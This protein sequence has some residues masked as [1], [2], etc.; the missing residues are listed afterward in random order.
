MND[1]EGGGETFAACS[2][3][4]LVEKVRR[5]REENWWR[6]LGSKG[7]GAGVGSGVDTR[8]RIEIVRAVVAAEWYRRRG[9]EWLQPRET[10]SRLEGGGIRIIVGEKDLAGYW[11]GVECVLLERSVVAMAVGRRGGI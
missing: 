6:C 5:R 11:G 8:G 4:W 10:R 7:G 2:R 1:S 9:T 3:A